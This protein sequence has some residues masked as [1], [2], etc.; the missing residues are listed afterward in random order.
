M[1]IAL[2]TVCC[3]VLCS[4]PTLAQK[5]KAAM[6]DQKF[7]DLAAQTDM[8]EANLGDLAQ[9][10][11]ASQAVKDYGR[12]VAGDH[13]QDYQKLQSLAQQT[14]LTL[15]TAIDSAHNKSL[16]SPLHALKGKAFDHK[17]IE[18]MVAGHTDALATYKKEAQD[19]TNPAIRSYAQATLPTLEKHLD[20]AK[21]IEQGKTPSM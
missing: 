8:I 5:T 9:D 15:P 21:A 17:Y 6:S 7:L 12:M 3:L 1:R 19:A 20:Q 4:L 18:D 13:S 11:A 10:A 14:G 16:I 2:T